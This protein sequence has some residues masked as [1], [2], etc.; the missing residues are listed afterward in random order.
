MA[1][2]EEV[3]PLARIN[4]L[5][6]VVQKIKDNS[7]RQHTKQQ[8]KQAPVEPTQDQPAWHIDEVV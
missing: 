6:K 3:A 4:K 7:A 2:I 8:S 1:E 5:K